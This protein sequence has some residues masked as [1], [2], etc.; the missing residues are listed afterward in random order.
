[1]GYPKK[2]EHSGPKRGQ[3]AYWGSKWEAK[4]KSSR[5]RRK[6][7]QREISQELDRRNTR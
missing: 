7:W 6:N 5:A 3:G 4:R 1:M 2:T